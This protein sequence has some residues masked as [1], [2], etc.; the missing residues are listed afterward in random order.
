MSYA[1]VKL[2]ADFKRDMAELEVRIDKLKAANRRII[3]LQ[4]CAIVFLIG[5]AVFLMW[6]LDL[7]W[8]NERYLDQMLNHY[9]TETKK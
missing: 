1:L 2:E 8:S 6:Q 3:V 5:L 4:N 7:A 9:T